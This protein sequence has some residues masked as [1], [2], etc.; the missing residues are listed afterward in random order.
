M[1]DAMI[2]ISK[3]LLDSSSLDFFFFSFS[4]WGRSRIIRDRNL[5]IRITIIQNEEIPSL[6]TKP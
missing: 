4:L 2:I 1:V 3:A 5:S 6:K